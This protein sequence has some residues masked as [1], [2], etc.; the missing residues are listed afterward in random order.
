MNLLILGGTVFL[1]RHLVEAALAR[2]HEVT[3]F[4]R[5]RNNPDLFPQVEKLI[6]DRDGD[7]RSLE[8]RRW[9]AVID[10]CGYIPR[11]VR[12]SAQ[13]LAGA[14]RHYTFTST[15][16]VYA[17][18]RAAGINETAPV[19]TVTD[20]NL[21]ELTAESYGPLKALCEKS[22]EDFMPGRT[23]V[24]RAGL[25]VGP[26]DPL[27]RFTYWVRRVVQGGDVLAPGRPERPVQIIDTRDLSE[28]IVRMIEQGQ[29][30]VYNG[31]GPDHSL[32]MGRLLEEAI[33]VSGSDARLI[34]VEDKFL[35][36]H[37][38]GAWNEVPLWLPENHP[39]MSS[40]MQVDCGRAFASGLTVRPLADTIRDTLAWDRTR[41]EPPTPYKLFGIELPPA[42]LSHERE[43]E[44]LEAWK[45]AGRSQGR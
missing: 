30:G 35:V 25:L 19:A 18:F 20:E 6:G 23:L 5:G 22:V 34:W 31:S 40:L 12:D 41:V 3:L 36:D 26:Y 27:E 39:T 8:G 17:D 16:G 24:I 33:T 38:A 9:D 14:V 42:G 2:R 45:G 37:N 21:E 4:N 44:L 1:G 15:I 32:T 7:L 43:I 10:T 29:T 11:Y 13:L 28:W